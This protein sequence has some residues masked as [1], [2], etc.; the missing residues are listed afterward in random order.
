[1]HPLSCLSGFLNFH[2]A[3]VGSLIAN[4]VD[5]TIMHSRESLDRMSVYIVHL[6]TIQVIKTNVLVGKDSVH[7]FAKPY[8]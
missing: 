5:C 2:Y 6:E 8:M 7:N 1:M 4:L 3:I